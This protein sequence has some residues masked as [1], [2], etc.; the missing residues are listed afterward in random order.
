[1]HQQLFH[2]LD[3]IVPVSSVPP[4]HNVHNKM[5][6]LK[7]NVQKLKQLPKKKKIITDNDSNA[8]QTSM[9][10]FKVKMYYI[11]LCENEI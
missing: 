10:S 2:V 5:A 1:M 9:Q 6:H 7:T 4:S 3:S 8:H 11:H